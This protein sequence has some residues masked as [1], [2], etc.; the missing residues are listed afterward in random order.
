LSL[1]ELWR[2]FEAASLERTRARD[3]D[4]AIAW[5]VAAL[6]R[7]RK[8]PTLG[9][10]IGWRGPQIQSVDQLRNVLHVLGA[11]YGGR[12]GPARRES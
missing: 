11:T 1:R 5:H 7:Q 3:R 4:L 8:L 6:S 2:E 12:V 9:S 10:L